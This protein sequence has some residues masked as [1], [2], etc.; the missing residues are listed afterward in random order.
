MIFSS[1]FFTFAFLPVPVTLYYLLGKQFRNI[2]L[3]TASLFFYAWGEPVL[4]MYG[5][6]LINYYI[7]RLLGKDTC[8]ALF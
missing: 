7:G 2:V 6:I 3:L 5:S 1:L 8:R 4:L